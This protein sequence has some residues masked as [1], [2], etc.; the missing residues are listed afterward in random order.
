MYNRASASRRCNV[1]SYC[2]HW[3]RQH[4]RRGLNGIDSRAR[5]FPQ[6]SEFRR[7]ADETA[8]ALDACWDWV[9]IGKVFY[10]AW[11]DLLYSLNLLQDIWCQ[12]VECMAV[13]H[14]FLVVVIPWKSRFEHK[15]LLPD[16]LAAKSFM[17]QHSLPIRALN[18][19][20]SRTIHTSAFCE[21]L[22][23]WS[24][25]PKKSP[26][27]T[28]LSRRLDRTHV[29]GPQLSGE[30]M[31]FWNYRSISEHP[32]TPAHARPSK[33]R[34]HLRR[35]GTAA[36]SASVFFEYMRYAKLQSLR[37]SRP[38]CI[39][40]TRCRDTVKLQLKIKRKLTT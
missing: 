7:D 26:C 29:P 23:F 27:G 2:Y 21:F 13:C 15:K 30:P 12:W 5:K 16:V 6:R 8:M 18:S 10:F 17:Q 9:S 36:G 32:H 1:P 28:I 37:I 3:S 14:P 39:W 31:V 19:K 33:L 38:C 25:W 11:N 20:Q 35:H 22:S 24:K 40:P 4:R 34:H